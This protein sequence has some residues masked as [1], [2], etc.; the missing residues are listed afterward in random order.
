MKSI[1]RFFKIDGE[2]AKLSKEVLAGFTTYVTMAYIIVVNPAILS[3]TGMDKGAVM[4]ATCLAAAIGTLLMG[5]IANYPF[6]LAPGM[7]LNAFFAY[8]I[9]GN[10]G[11]SWQAALA[12]VFLSGIIFIII[13]LTGLRKVIVEGIP[14]D[15]KTAISAGIGLFIAYIGVKDANLIKF[16]IEPGAYE[17]FGESAENSVAVANASAL[18]SFSI[19]TPVTLLAVIGLIITAILVINK[20]R[21]ALLSSIII[22]SVVGGLMQFAF[23]FD[24]G[25]TPPSDFSVPSLA[26][27]FGAFISGFNQ[28]VITGQGLGITVFSIIAVLISLTLV[29]MFDTI[30]T[31]I[32]TAAS[33]KMLDEDGKLPGVNKALLADAIA[34]A[35]GAVLGTSTTTTYI[36]SS[37]GVQAGGRTGF[38]SVVTG[39]L[40]VVSVFVAPLI[41][42]IPPAAISSVLIVVGVLMVPA[43]KN[44]DWKDFRVALPSFLTIIFMPFSYSISDGIAAGFIF[45]VITHLISGRGKEVSGVMYVFS[46]LFVIRY[47]LLI[48]Q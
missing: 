23:G 36:E 20:A 46:I 45:W 34:T 40:F 28:L 5:F 43:V 29:D 32:G 13:T 25:I 12:A 8:T 27:T 21:S 18:P 15:L 10:M 2:H 1:E 35:V 17:L 7:G 41:G 31:L 14:F 3:E 11:Y 16:T 19:D 38:T 39:L 26:P 37:A 6:A 48:L 47:V 30:G 24:V 4:V 33:A 9:C 22:T 44:I 42:F